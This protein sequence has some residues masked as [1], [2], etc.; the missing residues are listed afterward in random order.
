MAMLLV[1]TWMQVH[2]VLCSKDVLLADMDGMRASHTPHS[3]A[4]NMERNAV[5]QGVLLST[6]RDNLAVMVGAARTPADVDAIVCLGDKLQA[7]GAQVLAAQLCY[8]VAG[9]RPSP[10]DLLLAS[11]GQP[12]PSS[13][14]TQGCAMRYCLL[15]EEHSQDEGCHAS[16]LQAVPCLNVCLAR[17]A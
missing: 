12:A 8:L 9:L 10:F 5:A 3:T 7:E 17:T 13:S 6:W 4:A 14:S 2:H 16:C 11:R 15:G 1:S